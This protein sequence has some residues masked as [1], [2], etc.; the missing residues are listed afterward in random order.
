MAT[1]Y[2]IWIIRIRLKGKRY[3]IQIKKSKYPAGLDS[4]P[5][6]CTPLKEHARRLGLQGLHKAA[7]TIAHSSHCLAVTYN[8]LH[9]A[10]HTGKRLSKKVLLTVLGLALKYRHIFKT[11]QQKTFS[12]KRPSKNGQKKPI[13]QPKNC[14]LRQTNL[15][16][17]QISKIG[18]KMANLATLGMT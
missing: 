11:V 17:G 4:K 9:K 18:R 6:S 1:F 15:K 8:S 3:P 12:G 5:G 7:S 10:K 2:S 16:Y 14:R 13:G